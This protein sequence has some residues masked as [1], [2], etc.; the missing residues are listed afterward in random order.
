M[1]GIE[2]FAVAGLWRPTAESSNACAM[3]MVMVLV[4]GCPQMAKVHDRMPVLLP[5]ETWTAWTEAAPEVAFGL[6][7]VW[8]GELLAGHR[9]IRTAAMMSPGGRLLKFQFKTR[10]SGHDAVA[11]N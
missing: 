4:D 1:P 8:A 6:C 7:K 10:L 5:R 11:D 3:V 2:T 9:A